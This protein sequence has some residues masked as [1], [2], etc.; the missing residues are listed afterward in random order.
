[1]INTRRFSLDAEYGEVKVSTVIVKTQKPVEHSTVYIGSKGSE[2]KTMQKLLMQR[3]FSLP[4][5][6][7][8]GSFGRE[9]EKAVK[10]FQKANGLTQDGVCG[11]NTWALLDV[12]EVATTKTENT[13][14]SLGKI[15]T[16]IESITYTDVAADNSDSIDIIIDAQDDKWLNAWMPEKG[17]FLAPD[18]LGKDWEKEGDSH[19]IQCGTFVLDNLEYADAPTTMQMGGV[20]KPSDSDFS[21]LERETVWKNTSIKRIG[22]TI[23]DRYGLGFSFNAGDHNIACDEQDGT[24]SSYFNQLCK[25]YGLVLKVYAS[26]LWVYDREAYKEKKAVKTI[27]RTDIEPGSFRYSTTLSGTFTGGTFSYTD[28]DTDTD[29]SCSVGGGKHTKNVNRRASS[30]RDAMVQLCAEINNANHGTTAIHFTTDG[31]WTVSA[32]N[33]IEISGYGKLDGKYFVDKI[34]HQVSGAG[35]TSKFECSL[36][37]QG[38][39]PVVAQVQP[40]APAEE[41]LEAKAG[42]AIKLTKAALYVSSTAISR[43]NTIT[44]NYWLY[45]GKLINGRYQVANTAARCGA[46]PVGSNVTGWVDEKDCVVVSSGATSKPKKTGTKTG[47]TKKPVAVD[48]STFNGLGGKPTTQV[49]MVNMVK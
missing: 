18:I 29:I 22:K 7:A 4:K 19:K 16:E 31:E 41:K 42:A 10:D 46:Q 5:Y 40:E 25:N 2:V 27:Y 15:G 1:M 3:G 32:G 37:T 17:A 48:N 35:F 28:P 12:Q 44:G 43:A 39:K 11:K 23:A 6:G 49:Y 9:T 38:F 26:R 14:V 36:V 30:V 20:S 45:D 24:D 13:V 8:D 21:E 47:T 33:C 34:T